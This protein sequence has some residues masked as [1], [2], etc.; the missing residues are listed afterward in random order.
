MSNNVVNQVAFLQ[1]TR[2]FPK[3]AELLSVELG[4]SYIDIAATVNSRIISIFPTVHPAI[5]GE[6]WF[7][8][9]NLKQEGLRQVYPITGT[10]SYPHGIN[11]SAIGGFTKIYGTFTDGT[12][13]YPLPFV[14]V[15]AA[16]NQVNLFVGG[17]NI[18]VT[19][20]GGAGQPVVLSGFV[21]LE[22]ISKP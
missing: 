9:N 8:K 2:I 15:V 21:V 3:D 11:L 10:G 6:Q 4:K 12:S 1:T 5:T 13:W 16:N 19:G 22:W 18:F 7:I 20:G 17:T 14:S